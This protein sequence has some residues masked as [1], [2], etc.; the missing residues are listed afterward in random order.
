MQG[1]L[2][3]MPVDLFAASSTRRLDPSSVATGN[4]VKEYWRSLTLT[5][6]VRGEGSQEEHSLQVII[7]QTSALSNRDLR[8]K[9]EPL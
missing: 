2:G 9:A 4:I 7:Q 3:G 5:V 1:W 6:K 8:L